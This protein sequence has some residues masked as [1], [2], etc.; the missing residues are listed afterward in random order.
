MIKHDL[1]FVGRD[2]ALKRLKLLLG[3]KSASLVVVKGRR[4]IGK[5]RLIEEFGKEHRFLQFAGLPPEKNITAQSQRD[6]FASR[7]GHYCH[8]PA[9]RSSDWSELFQVLA[10]Q[11]KEGRVVILLDEISWMAAGDPT[12]LGKLKNAWDLEFKK[13][14]ELILILCGSV[15]VWIEEN[16]LSSTG[17]FGRIP[18]E[19]TLGELSLSECNQLLKAQQF[20]GTSYEKLQ[21]LSITGGV[22]WYLEQLQPGFTAE[23]NIKHLCFTAGGTLVTEFDKIFHDLF[24]HKATIYKDII[25]LLANGS[26][27]NQEIAAA[28]NYQRSGALSHY[29]Q[30]LTISS[31]ITRDLSWRLKDGKYGRF[32]KYRLSDNYLRFYLKFIEPNLEKIRRDDYEEI[33]LGTF[34]GY[35]TT[36]GLQFE[37]LVIKNRKKLFEILGININEVL[38]DNPYFQRKTKRQQGC[39]IDYLIQT[40]LNTLFVFEIKFSK[41]IIGHSVINDVQEKIRRLVVPKH[42]ACVPILVHVNG[43]SDAVSDADYFFRIINFSEL[44]S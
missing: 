43:V 31:F 15:S 42:F 20:V 27:E 23:Q 8:F 6:S 1:P 19:I 10:D 30:Q 22:P 13:N 3:K 26:L 9:P 21:L 12:F 2:Q 16:I 39:Q 24:S 5:S 38:S 36:L 41:N 17:Y 33:H 28:L 14:A 7:L 4:R 29:L 40:R 44:L 35:A 32:S 18:T 34:P 37:N 25:R 11:T